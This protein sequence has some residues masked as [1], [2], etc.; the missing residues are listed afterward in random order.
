[1]E[2][3]LTRA[4]VRPVPQSGLKIGKFELAS[5]RPLWRYAVFTACLFAVTAFAVA[6]RL[7]VQQMRKDMHRNARM[8]R[9]A[10]ILNDRLHLEMDARRRAAAVEVVAQRMQL[11]PKARIVSVEGAGQ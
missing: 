5:L 9:E 2:R 8:Q 10:T 1:M 7:D 3:T 11:G 4:G 6:V